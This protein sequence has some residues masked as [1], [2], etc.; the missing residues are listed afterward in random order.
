MV[1]E[2]VLRLL[3]D[4]R[5]VA[6]LAADQLTLETRQQIAVADHQAGRPAAP[7]GVDLFT[8]FEVQR[9]VQAHP[10]AGPD[11]PL[12][13]AGDQLAVGGIVCH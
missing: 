5:V 4:L 7:R 6:G 8:R 10:V 12:G 11:A 2:R 13:G 3:Q 9:E 1:A